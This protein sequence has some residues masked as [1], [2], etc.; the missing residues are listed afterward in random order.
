MNWI[1]ATTRPP[2]PGY[3]AVR[4]A[5][6]MAPDVAFFGDI[7]WRKGGRALF[8]IEAWLQLPPYTPPADPFGDLRPCRA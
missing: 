2:A 6:S 5:G 7:G 1:P 3:Y 4:H 8:G